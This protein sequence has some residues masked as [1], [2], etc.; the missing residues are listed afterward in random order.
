[1][2]SAPALIVV[3]GGKMG[4]ALVAGLL[5]TGWGPPDAMAVV[6]TDPGRR[7][8]LVARH[9]ALV[10][11]DQVAAAVGGAGRAVGG[12]VV[13]VK[14]VDAEGACRALGGAGVR[15]VLS[16]AAGVTLASLESWLAEAGGGGDPGHAQH[17]GPGGQ[18]GRGYRRRTF[19]REG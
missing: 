17:P 19:G 11:V 3:G 18:R 16:I 7:A 4:E 10:V 2:G 1:M 12:A 6:E 8:E 5:R 15:R 13:A 9:P 14:P